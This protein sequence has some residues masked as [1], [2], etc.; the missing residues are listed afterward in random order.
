MVSNIGFTPIFWNI[1]LVDSY[2][3]RWVESRI[4]CGLVDCVIVILLCPIHQSPS[5]NGREGVSAAKP[6]DANIKS[7]NRLG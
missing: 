1:N 5:F 2:F 4:P 6:P 7:P 3:F